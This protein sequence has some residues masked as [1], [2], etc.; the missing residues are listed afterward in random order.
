MKSLTRRVREKLKFYVYLYVDPRDGLPFY[1]GKGTGNRLLAHLQD[2]TESE[3]VERITELRK[4]KLE[5]IIEIL[6]Y[7][8]SEEQALLIESAA[9]DLLGLSQ[10]LNRV[11]GHHASDCGRGRLEEVVQELDAE[12]AEITHP[13]VLINVSRMY[14]YGLSALDLYDVTRGVWKVGPRRSRAEFAF[15]INGGIIRAVYEI[16]AWVP[17]GSTM[18]TRTF[19]EKDYNLGERF[20][21]VGNIASQAMLK[22]YIGKSVKSYF[23]PGAQN[24]IKYVK[25]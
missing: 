10:L 9:I 12:E 21:F 2:S 4:L 3:K 15:C 5:P 1:V 20:E 23:A 19:E 17:A 22:R 11:K 6:K 13:A 18:T 8:L 16:A 7:G 14:R 24:P 25:C